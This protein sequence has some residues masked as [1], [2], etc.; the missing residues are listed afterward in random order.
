MMMMVVMPT[1]RQILKAGE[2][3]AGRGI[4]EVRRKLVQLSRRCRVPCGLGTLGGC[5]QVRGDLMCDLLV[6]G[7]VRLLKLL[8]RV[9]HLDER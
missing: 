6:L 9:H 2:L 5:L 7:W 3:A 1:H 4:G 8:E